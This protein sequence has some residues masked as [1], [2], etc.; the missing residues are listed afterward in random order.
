VWAVFIL[1]GGLARTGVA[2]ILGRQ[3][4]RIA[5]SGEGRLIM[6]IMLT[7]AVLSA[8][9]NNV[10]VAALLLPVVMDISKRTGR[11]PSKLLIPLS[12]SCL[13]GGL[14]TQIGTPPNILVTAAL[15]D[16]GTVTPLREMERC[17]QTGGPRSDHDRPV[18]EPLL[19][20]GRL[21]QGRCVHFLDPVRGHGG[22][23]F[24]DEMQV[25]GEAEDGLPAAA[26]Q[27]APDDLERGDVLLAQPRL[28]QGTREELPFIP[29]Q[30]DTDL[31][32]AER[33][34]PRSGTLR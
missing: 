25:D 14:T 22:A 11:P 6:V 3:V 2:G 24:V 10:G 23:R 21:G 9:M 30:G 32:H 29:V 28:A 13:L 19:S 16:E 8:F 7:A 15:E 33:H 12:F 5:G 4:L 26:I 17:E 1:S 34:G 20:A 31:V 27:G 18:V